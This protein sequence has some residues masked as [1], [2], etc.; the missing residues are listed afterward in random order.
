VTITVRELARLPHLQVTVRAGA[1]GLDNAI[2]WV[3]TSD[4]PNPW[5]WL[6]AHEFLLTN[7][8]GMGPDPASQAAFVEQLAAAAASGLGYG[9]GTGPPLSELAVRQAARLGLPLVTVPFSV[10]FTTVVRAVADANAREESAQLR[11]VARL[12]EV[13]RASLLAGTPGSEMMRQLGNELKVRLYLVDPETG[14][15]LLAGAEETS[16]APALVS[17]YAAHGT[18]LPGILRLTRTPEATDRG[19]DGSTRGGP[20]S[21]V[22]VAVPGERP[23]ALVVESEGGQ[24]PSPVLLQ[25]LATS[26]ALELA[27]LAATRQRLRRIGADLLSEL[28]NQRYEESSARAQLAE[29]NIDLATSV[30]LALPSPDPSSE[31]AVHAMLARHGA[32]HLLRRTEGATLVLC[33]EAELAGWLSQELESRELVAGVSSP[34]DDLARFRQA[35]D[36]ARWALAIASMER[37]S[38]V[39]Y[40][41]QTNLMAPRTPTEANAVATRTLGT[42][43]D[44]DAEHGTDYLNTLRVLLRNDR[45]WQ[46]AAAILSIHKQTLGYRLRR[47]EAVSGRG[48]VRTDHIAEWWVALRAYDLL[49]GPLLQP[50]RPR[51]LPRPETPHLSPPVH[52]RSAQSYQGKDLVAEAG[53]GDSGEL[54]VVVARRNFHDVG[55]HEIEPGEAAQQS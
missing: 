9:I 2:S 41:D 44:Y 16:F 43:L 14:Q 6:G 21:A 4:L 5:E 18:A 15:S 31:E 8:I 26:S 29:L 12:Y 51:L 30:L 37:R 28:L 1:E 23:T 13:L 45:S 39:R 40:G 49:T 42:L 32:P 50:A 34:V 20:I 38:L 54:G 19:G 47:I 36:E 33:H 10:S 17:S 46:R 3:H 55:T 24:L 11:H 22:A 25:H 35:A 27:Q 7:G 52:E 53:G 48:V